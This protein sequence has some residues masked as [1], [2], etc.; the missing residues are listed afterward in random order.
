[1]FAGCLTEEGAKT[2]KSKTSDQLITIICDITKRDHILNA[3][4]IVSSSSPDGLWT[5]VNNA[6]VITIMI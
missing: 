6:Y 5:L 1:M 3:A 4:K 2:L